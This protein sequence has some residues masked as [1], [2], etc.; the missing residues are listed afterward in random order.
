M[1]IAFFEIEEHEKDYLKNQLKD[2]EA[3][4]FAEKLDSKN[5]NAAKDCQIISVFIDSQITKEVL[6]VLP[7]VKMIATR[8]TGFDHIDLQACAKNNVVVCNVPHYGDNSVAEHAFALILSLSRKIP[9]SI[10]RVKSGNFSFEGLVGFDLKRKTI[11]IVG[12]G[13]IGQHMARIARGFEMN[14]LAYDVREDKKLAKKLGFTYVSFEDLLKN[15][16][17]ITLHIPY[18]KSTHHLIN[19]SNIHLI[20]KGAY[21]INTSRGGIIETDALFKA[22]NS[23]IILGAGLDVLEEENFIKEEENLLSKEFLKKFDLKT[24]LEDHILMEKENVLITPHNAFNTK[25]ALERILE[26][27]VLN[28]KSFVKNKPIN[29]VK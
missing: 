3:S 24:V 15:S 13:N 25:E 4:F 10:Q 7:N 16:D 12:L 26:T 17:I 20:K 2:A 22:L 28:I 8:S 23:G 29:I 6:D 5:V 9:Q 14:V 21:V 19:S 18:N 11:G 27:T 1:K